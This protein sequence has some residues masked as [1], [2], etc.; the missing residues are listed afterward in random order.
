MNTQLHEEFEK[1]AGADPAIYISEVLLGKLALESLIDNLTLRVGAAFQIT[2]TKP[3]SARVSRVGTIKNPGNGAMPDGKLSIAG[4][5]IFLE[6]V[7]GLSVEVE[8]GFNDSPP[9]SAPALVDH[10]ATVKMDVKR[11]KF[12]INVMPGKLVIEAADAV[13]IPEILSVISDDDKK[14]LAEK[15][16]IEKEELFRIEGLLAYSGIQVQ[17][18]LSVSEPKE[19]DFRRLFYGLTLSGELKAIVSTNTTS[20]TGSRVLM[21]VPS[22]GIAAN[23]DEQCECDASDNGIGIAPGSEVEPA[24]GEI[25]FG[26][27]GPADLSKIDFGLSQQG[28]GGVG[29]YIPRDLAKV[30]VDGVFP[31]IRVDL[32]NNGFVG[33][34]AHAI[35]DFGDIDFDFVPARLELE[36]KIGFRLAAHGRIHIDLGKIGKPKIGEFHADQGSATANLIVIRIRPA[37]EEGVVYLKPYIAYISIGKFTVNLQFF[38]H[39]LSPFGAAT[40]LLGFVIDRILEPIFAHNMPFLIRDA[41]KKYFSNLRWKLV[42]ARYYGVLSGIVSAKMQPESTMSMTRDSLLVGAEWVNYE[43]PYPGNG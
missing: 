25:K 4:I 16:G 31:A 17:I 35:A 39:V 29:V 7:D 15:Y 12:I 20:L 41:I 18:A 2:N 22:K 38:S 14:F 5:D 26:G 19:I 28:D 13:F 10:F 33:F 24:T 6:V 32:A 30:I 42:D 21:I 27:V 3:F 9:G 40:A 34:K 1:Y 8:I 37:I 23:S 11:F 36:V 43:G